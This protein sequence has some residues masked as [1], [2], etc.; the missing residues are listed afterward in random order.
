VSPTT[1]AAATTTVVATTV[2]PTT[3]APTT[4][5]GGDLQVITPEGTETEVVDDDLDVLV[6]GELPATGSPA[7]DYLVIAGVLLVTGWFLGTVAGARKPRR[8]QEQ[9]W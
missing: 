1:T 5:P 7:A 8:R 2:A 4:I 6:P 3:I 9:G